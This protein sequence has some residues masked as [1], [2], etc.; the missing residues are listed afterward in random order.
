MQPPAQNRSEEVARVRAYI[1]AQ[2]MKRTP[3]Q[4]VEAVQEAQQQFEAAFALIPAERQRQ[5]PTADEWSAQD[6]LE[7]MR[8]MA[9]FDLLAM[10][11]ILLDDATPPPMVDQI[12]RAP[13]TMTS[14]EI[15]ADFQRSRE[16]VTA[17]VLAANPE[18]H[19]D[20]LISHPEFGTF[21]WRE[22]LL[23]ARVHLLDH[24]RQLQGI[25]SALG[26]PSERGA[27]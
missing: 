13:A 14:A 10:T 16:E 18:A 15:L 7:H 6:V 23:F 24:A 22:V 17:I 5:T 12:Q 27:P 20:R 8:T 1:V 9:Q 25:A 19:L 4:I 21:N 2:A 26:I 11:A 3:A